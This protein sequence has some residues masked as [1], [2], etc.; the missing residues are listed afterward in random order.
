LGET[1]ELI[2]LQ[3]LVHQFEQ[4]LD[5]LAE[6]RRDVR[7]LQC[8]L[9]I[10][11][12]LSIGAELVIKYCELIAGRAKLR[13]IEAELLVS[14]DRGFDIAMRAC[15]CGILNRIVEIARAREHAGKQR[16]GVIEEIRA[17]LRGNRGGERSEKRGRAGDLRNQA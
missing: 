4:V 8:G 6:L 17:A 7:H 2:G 9:Q 1:G 15:G 3:F 10:T 12:R 13:I 16:I 11:A 14:A 5:L